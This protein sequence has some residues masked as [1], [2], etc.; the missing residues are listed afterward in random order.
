M[1][2][3]KHFSTIVQVEQRYDDSLFAFVKQGGY[4]GSLLRLV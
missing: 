2:A 3:S 4:P 1:K